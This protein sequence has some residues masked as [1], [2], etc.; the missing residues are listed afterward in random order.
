M[1]YSRPGYLLLLALLRAFHTSSV[2]LTLAIIVPFCFS[3]GLL[4]NPCVTLFYLLEQADM[5]I[6]GNTSRVSDIRLLL[7]FASHLLIS[8]FCFFLTLPL[9]NDDEPISPQSA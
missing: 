4:S 2:Y 9:S 7:S 1:L 6:F 8:L 5:Y 3:F